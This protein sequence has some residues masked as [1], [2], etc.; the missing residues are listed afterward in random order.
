MAT[1]LE[2]VGHGHEQVG[3]HGDERLVHDQVHVLA[4]PLEV[5]DQLR[6]EVVAQDAEGVEGIFGVHF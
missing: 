2:A 3:E 6:A 5:A 1:D 4:D